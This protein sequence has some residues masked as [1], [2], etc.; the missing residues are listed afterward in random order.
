MTRPV[1]SALVP[2]APP[3]P[4]EAEAALPSPSH[5]A[6]LPHDHLAVVLSRTGSLAVR[7]VAQ[8]APSAQATAFVATVRHLLTPLAPAV[9]QVLRA[10]AATHLFHGVASLLDG[11]AAEASSLAEAVQARGAEGR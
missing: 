2:Q 7:A 5:L 10:Q 6:L 4:A 11:I 8:P 9:S 1:L 3:A